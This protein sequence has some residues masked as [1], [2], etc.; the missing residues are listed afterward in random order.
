M[1]EPLRPT[2]ASLYGKENWIFVLTVAAGTLI[3]TALEANAA[4]GLDI[5]NIL[6]ADTAK[7]SQTT[8]RVTQ[9][10]RVGDTVLAEFIGSTT[11]QGGEMHYQF[12]PQAAL[13]SNGKKAFEKFT[14]AGTSGFLIE[15]LG[16]AKATT[17]AAG[18]FVNVYP[19]QI[20]P[21]FPARAGDNET[22]EAGMTATFAVTAAP[23]ISVALT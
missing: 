1:A 19:V 7:P 17:P 6:F 9:E 13:A 21:S 18:Q 23:A 14:A 4:T 5:T 16:V 20:G 3:P 12:D 2:P 11:Y 15:R 10:R 22:A 8:N